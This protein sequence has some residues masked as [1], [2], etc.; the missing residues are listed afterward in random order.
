MKYK[1]FN[2]LEC[3]V[4][5]NNITIF[6]NLSLHCNGDQEINDGKHKLAF[7]LKV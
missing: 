2:Y 7:K 3:V 6:S 1:Y 5:K 4:K